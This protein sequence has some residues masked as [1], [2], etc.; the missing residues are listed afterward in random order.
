MKTIIYLLLFFLSTSVKAKTVPV[1]SLIG[2]QGFKA[3]MGH[4]PNSNS[5]EHLRVKCH[6]LYVEY[7]LRVKS[8]NHL[9]TN[10]KRKRAKIL[11]LLHSYA[12]A[13]NYPKNNFLEDVRKPCFI[14]DE[15]TICAVGYLL[16]STEGRTI[17]ENV[18]AQYQYA[19]I[20]EMDAAFIESWANENGLTLEE[21]AMIQ[22]TY[23]WV[24]NRQRTLI[25]S[26]GTSLRFDQSYYSKFELA[27]AFNKVLQRRFRSSLSL[28]YIPFRNG[29]YSAALA[30]YK[31]IYLRNRIRLFGGAGGEFFAINKED[32]LNLVPEVGASYQYIKGRMVFNTQLAY[33]YH[34]GLQN[35]AAYSPNR[36]EVSALIGIGFSL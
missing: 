1:N 19:E 10:K 28:Q 16:E 13:G 24:P 5:D 26:L 6:L 2:D 22:P 36:N 32:G 9:S 7:L 25:F 35:S 23:E 17:A 4:Y 3:I 34:I 12:L 27:F 20:Y 8:T 33:S 14:D 29:S 11:D 15:G 21:C 18:N 31:T 30:Y